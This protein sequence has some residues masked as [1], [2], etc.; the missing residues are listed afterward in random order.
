MNAA[1]KK[2]SDQ[3]QRRTH[4][5]PLTTNYTA[6]K[7]PPLQYLRNSSQPTERP[8][9]WSKRSNSIRTKTIHRATLTRAKAF[10]RTAFHKLQPP[11]HRESNGVDTMTL[12]TTASFPICICLTSSPEAP[13][14]CSWET[15]P[16]RANTRKSQS[17]RILFRL[18]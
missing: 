7:K 13:D 16:R 15:P 8:E 11:F 10:R 1:P 9:K 18:H 5:T 6:R 17:Q 3:I 4:S 2:A 14:G 12:S